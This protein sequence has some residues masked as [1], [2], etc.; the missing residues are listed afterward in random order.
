MTRTR[1]L[2]LAAAL[3]PLAVLTAACGTDRAAGPGGPTT[4]AP[5]QLVAPAAFAATVDRPGVVTVNVH[6]PHGE[7]I[8]GTDLV[9][10]FDRI[11]A[12]PEL[13]TDRSTPLA[14]YCRSGNMSA[15]AA[16]DLRAMGYTHIVELDGGYDAWLASGRS[17]QPSSVTPR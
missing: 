7:D 3:V 8:P 1:S 11:T 12:S 16:R 9:I 5:S 2:L 14:I 17:M 10:P 15:T 13:P 6:V 4:S